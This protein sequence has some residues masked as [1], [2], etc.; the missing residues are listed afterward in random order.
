MWSHLFASVAIAATLAAIS[1]AQYRNHH[2]PPTP[3]PTP[4]PNAPA[5]LLFSSEFDTSADFFG[6]TAKWK[7]SW[8]LGYG[9]SSNA[10]PGEV[11]TY[12][13]V[14]NGDIRGPNPFT[15]GQSL[16]G[17][18]ATPN[19]NLNHYPFTYTSGCLSTAG[20][21]SFQYGYAEIR[22]QAPSGK[23]FWPTFWMM[24]WVG[25]WDVVWPP[26]IDVFQ[27]SSRLPNEYYPAVFYGTGQEAGAFVNTGT[28]ISQGMH[29]Y[30]FEWT[31]STMNWFF[32]GKLVMTQ[33]SPPGTAVPMFLMLSLAV[34]DNSGWIGPPDGS[35]ATWWI[36]YVRVYDRK[37][38]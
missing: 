24:K 37:P 2:R 4:P 16:L 32:D 17:I 27:A 36:D 23:G 30:G 22:C 12:I 26:E 10:T 8:P 6:P 35:V 31:A 19:P 11:E 5:K 20:L 38:S 9:W 1:Y 3:I 25:S 14:Q 28:N 29:T 33:K 7:S 13:D 34:G 21:F 15:Q 18:R